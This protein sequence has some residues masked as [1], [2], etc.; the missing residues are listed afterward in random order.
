LRTRGMLDAE[1]QLA[2]DA[3][4]VSIDGRPLEG[5]LPAVDW[6]GFLAIT[7]RHR[8]QAQCWHGLKPLA[9]QLP[10]DVRDALPGQGRAI[11]ASNLAATAESARLHQ[12][13]QA[14]KVPLIFVKG[15]TLAALVYRDPMLKM[16]MD[17][18]LLID[19]ARL[20][21]AARL[22]GSAGYDCVIP[23]VKGANSL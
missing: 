21:D 23:R 2:V 16:S 12:M 10:L 9:E 6:A 14:E 11:V 5:P 1:F 19:P 20:A 17:I 13:F 15:L 7:E 3:C 4:R 18:D 8:V 22:L